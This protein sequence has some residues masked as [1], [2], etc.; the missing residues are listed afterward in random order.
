MFASPTLTPISP[1]L[2][3]SVGV[4]IVFGYLL[5]LAKRLKQIPKIDYFT[6]KVN[7]GIRILLSGIGTLGVTWAWSPAGTGHQILITI[8]AWSALA[9]G[10]WHW[11]IQ[12]GMQHGFESVLQ[13]NKMIS[14][15]TAAAKP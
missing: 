9:L 10:L 7:T 3:T 4:A 2:P 6:T 13:S 11:L 15:L 12:Y 14:D 1:V 8:P 5:D